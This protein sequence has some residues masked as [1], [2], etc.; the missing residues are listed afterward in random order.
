MAE[1]KV[2][3]VTIDDIETHPNADRLEMAVIGGYRSAVIKGA[4]RPGDKVAYIPEGSVL[5]SDLIEE[6]GLTGRLAG[7]KSDRVKAIRLRGEVSQ[8][9]VYSG[10]A[11]AAGKPGDDL[12]ETLG[13]TKYVPRVPASMNGLAKPGPTVKGFDVENWQSYPNVLK[14][15]ER[16]VATEK[17]HGTWCGLGYEPAFGPVVTSKGLSQRGLCF[18]VEAESN[19]TNLYCKVWHK[20]GEA[21]REYAETR[22]E[23]VHVLGEVYGRGVQDLWYGQTNPA[24][25]VFA[26]RCGAFGVYRWHEYDGADVDGL[27]A[28]AARLG[29]RMVPKLLDGGFDHQQALTLAQGSTTTGGKHMREGVVVQAVPR[30]YDQ[31]LGAV[32]LKYVNP[33]YLTRKGGTEL[34]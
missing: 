4:Y 26:I 13:I 22:G 5:P 11:V 14:H 3:I 2:S 34:N 16:V 30:R 29:F 17:L 23:P 33:G 25:S 1:H 6:L 27:E 12:T 18:D 21:V 20:H 24:F 15:G 31:S 19:Q 7:P 10:A 8:G 9:L 28:T 32:M